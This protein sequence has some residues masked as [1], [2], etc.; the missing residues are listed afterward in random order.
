MDCPQKQVQRGKVIG[1]KIISMGTLTTST[2]GVPLT[3]TTS[4]KT[5][6]GL[7]SSGLYSMCFTWSDHQPGER[8]ARPVP[9]D[10]LAWVHILVRL[11]CGLVPQKKM[12]QLNYNSPWPF[13]FHRVKFAFWSPLNPHTPHKQANPL[14]TSAPTLPLRGLVLHKNSLTHAGWVCVW[15]DVW[16]ELKSLMPVTLCHHNSSF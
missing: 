2:S 13:F 12:V 16:H 10:V 7:G 5:L 6:L 4:S 1:M 3:T 8:F 9:K 15:R 14:R 11:I